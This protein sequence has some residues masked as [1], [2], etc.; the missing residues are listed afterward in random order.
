V[1]GLSLLVA[2]LA[3]CALAGTARADGDPAS[4]YL[5]VQKVFLPFDAK[6]P[7][8]RQAEFVALVNAA[9]ASGF[10]I[11]VALI[12]SAYDLGAITALWRKPRPYA[13]FLGA[14]LAFVYK[15]RLLIVMPNGFGFHWLR[16]PVER[17]YSV[18]SKIPIKPGSVGL[19]DAGTTAVRR[20]AADS[21][22]KLVVPKHV[23]TQTNRNSHDR[24]VIILAVV[25]ALSVA[26]LLRLA[27][28]VRRR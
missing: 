23:T 15:Q 14:E 9:N 12:S 8:K 27:L 26:L 22:V 4:D 7:Q 25:A 24:L 19:L 13:R 2:A 3:A 5:L 18:L 20:L 1:K 6:F 11:R 28:R 10:K 17:E 16:H 21:G